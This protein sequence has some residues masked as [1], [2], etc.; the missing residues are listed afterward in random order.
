MTFSIVLPVNEVQQVLQ[1]KKW[2]YDQSD[3]YHLC[4]ENE[5]FDEI[6]TYPMRIH[7]VSD[8]SSRLLFYFLFA[9]NKLNKLNSRNIPTRAW[10]QKLRRWINSSTA[11]LK[12]SLSS[13]FRQRQIS[14]FTTRKSTGENSQVNHPI[15]I[16]DFPLQGRT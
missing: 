5:N 16:L 6:I 13:S 8:I 1:N 2:K 14:S 7:V 12:P 4:D 15:H 9:G 3:I 11:G 10:S